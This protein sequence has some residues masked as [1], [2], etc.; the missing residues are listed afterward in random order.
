MNLSVECSNLSANILKAETKI[1]KYISDSM[2]EQS[3]PIRTRKATKSKVYFIISMLSS[4]K[5]VIVFTAESRN[6]YSGKEIKAIFSATK[7]REI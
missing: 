4:A 3:L 1:K 2:K 6:I 5:P 7:A